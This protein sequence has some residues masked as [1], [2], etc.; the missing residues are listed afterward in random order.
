VSSRS[1]VARCELQ[2]KKRVAVQRLTLC[3]HRDG[4]PTVFAV[5]KQGKG[6]DDI[7]NLIIS[8]WKSSG[9][10]ELS[11]ERWKRDGKKGSGEV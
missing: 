1:F 6:V 11:E 2:A 4:G 10:Y 5:V 8:A 9:A 7:V 3:V